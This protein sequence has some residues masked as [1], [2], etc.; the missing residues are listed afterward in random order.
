[1]HASE[2]MNIHDTTYIHGS[3]IWVP[4]LSELYYNSRHPNEPITLS[5]YSSLRMGTTVTKSNNI[6]SFLIYRYAELQTVAG[7]R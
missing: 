3:I 6:V 1:M 4:Q 7:K 5:V 2:T